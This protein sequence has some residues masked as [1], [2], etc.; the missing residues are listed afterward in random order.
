M[1]ENKSFL[2]SFIID[3]FFSYPKIQAARNKYNQAVKSWKALQKIPS[4]FCPSVCFYKF[5][6]SVLYHH[7]YSLGLEV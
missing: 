3:I 4:V 2:L 6:T 1:I 5:P 7:I